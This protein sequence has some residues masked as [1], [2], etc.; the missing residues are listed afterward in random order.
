MTRS[1]LIIGGIAV[2]ILAVLG[3]AGYRSYLAP[4]SATPGY[5]PSPSG[6]ESPTL[7]SA[8]GKI[9]PLQNATLAFRMAGRIQKVGVKEGD[10]VQVGDPL[11]QLEANDLQAAVDQAQA[12]VALAQAQ[13]D[14]VKAGARPEE[15]AAAE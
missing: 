8:E 7:V 3:Y 11:I 14:Q 13:L 1:R 9:I 12:A 5:T 2:L 15:I 4:G 10:T 6:P